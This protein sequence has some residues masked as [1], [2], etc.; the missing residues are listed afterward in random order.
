MPPQEA[1]SPTRLAAV[2]AKHTKVDIG[3]LD[4]PDAISAVM[5][6]TTLA[7]TACRRMRL[8]FLA[9]RTL[10]MSLKAMQAS[11]ALKV[12]DGGMVKLWVSA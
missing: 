6:T 8:N 10:N 2:A 4:V 3:S 11:E 1:E 9:A 7:H 12:G 5:A